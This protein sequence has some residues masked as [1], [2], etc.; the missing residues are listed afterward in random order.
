M[1]FFTRLVLLSTMLL[2]LPALA[3]ESN[4][5]VGV[6]DAAKVPAVMARAP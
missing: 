4:S 3:Q 1:R 2:P 6:L 5:T